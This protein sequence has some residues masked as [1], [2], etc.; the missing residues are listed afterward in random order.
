[1][2]A[3]QTTAKTHGIQARKA[4]E[5]GLD[6]LGKNQAQAA[7]KAFAQAV[8][9]DPAHALAY[10]Q[11]GN[12]LRLTGD[13]A[14]AEKALKEAIKLDQGLNEAYISL[15]YL[16]R[17]QGR[18]EEATSP[19]LSLA[20][21]HPGDGQL[22][23][24]IADLLAD[25]DSPAQA[26][27]IYEE[28]LK[29]S[30]RSAR[31]HLKLGLSYQKM[32]RFKEAEG[33]LLKAIECDPGSD[34]AYLRLA[35]TRRWQPEDA[36]L[37]ERL[38]TT[39]TRSDLAHDTRVCLN[40]AL[41]KMYDDLKLYERA[42]GHFHAGNAL[43]R[44]GLEFDHEAMASY[45]RRAKEVCVPGSFASARKIGDTGPAP[46]FVVGMLRSGTTLVERILASHP[47]ARGLGETEMVDGLA[48]RLV[49]ATGMAYPDCLTRLDPRM[50]EKLAAEFRA[51]WPADVRGVTRVVDKNPLNFLHLG[52]IALVFPEARILHCVRDPLDCC[53]SVYF[54]HFAHMRNNYAYDLEDI[55][56]FYDRY[57]DLMAHG[58]SV[59][60][61]QFHE[62]GYE[63]LTQDTEATSRGLVAAAGLAWHPDC[64][65]PHENTAD[66]STASIWQARQPINRDS[67]G[68]WRHYARHLDGLRHRLSAT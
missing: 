24:Q 35:H 61:I 18:R 68:R 5:E 63:A 51:G 17:S 4:Y 1:M 34:A 65:M 60:Q 12:C 19:L 42:F 58:R 27:S 44:K 25:M 20:A 38:E 30:P 31:A 52:L 50:A 40:F 9:L 45:V 21:R 26:A 54:Q 22:Q 10:Y 36:P 66:I 2:S 39:L 49:G 41:G 14:G 59:L 28:C 57:T 67:V 23:L 46:V 64:L 33:A 56:F 55:A 7:A 43:Q 53:L 11:L 16:Y 8:A 62:V 47:D 6:L 13:A 15:A 3:P 37:L 32:G 48:Q 29:H